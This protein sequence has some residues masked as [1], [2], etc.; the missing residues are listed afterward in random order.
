MTFVLTIVAIFLGWTLAG[1]INIFIAKF[2]KSKILRE[3][4]DPN[5]VISSKPLITWFPVFRST[6]E[7]A[8]LLE[9]GE[10]RKVFISSMKVKFF[11]S[12]FMAGIALLIP[13]FIDVNS[14]DDE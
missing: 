10:I 8:Q 2:Y 3:N 1:I 7:V 13:F 12:L 5:Y 14:L 4:H 9:G 11:T 6:H